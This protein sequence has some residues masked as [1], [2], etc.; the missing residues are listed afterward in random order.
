MLPQNI[1]YALVSTGLIS[2]VPLNINLGAYSPALVVGDG[3]ISFGGAQNAGELMETLASGAA[4]AGQRQGG[5]AAGEGQKAAITQGPNPALTGQS[6]TPDTPGNEAQANDVLP[7]TPEVQ[8]VDSKTDA[9]GGMISKGIN[10]SVKMPSS[11]LLPRPNMHKRSEPSLEIREPDLPASDAKLIRREIQGFREA[12]NFAINAMKNQPE[13][14]LGTGQE[15]SGVGVIVNP[16]L[17]VPAGSPAAGRTNPPAQGAV[18]STEKA[19][20]YVMPG[21]PMGATGDQTKSG[22]TLMAIA[23]I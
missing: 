3:E 23:E 19:R 12:L 5:A 1:L 14:E 4:T 15:G 22:I 11:D 16:G 6:A 2:A 8:V 20:R 18:P 17:N 10:P 7:D 13:V 21:A 9:V